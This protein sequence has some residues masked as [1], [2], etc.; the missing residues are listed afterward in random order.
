M[1]GFRLEHTK[2]AGSV[3]MVATAALLRRMGYKWWDLGMVM[4]YKTALGAKVTPREEF[5]RRYRIDRSDSTIFGIQ[6]PMQ[7]SELIKELVSFQS[8]AD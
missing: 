7:A 6:N 2:G 5:L 1:T 3:Q 8:A 4:K